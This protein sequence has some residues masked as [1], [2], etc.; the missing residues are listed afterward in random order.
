MMQA[1]M[2]RDLSAVALLAMRFSA[3]VAPHQIAG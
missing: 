2:L 1:P 3:R